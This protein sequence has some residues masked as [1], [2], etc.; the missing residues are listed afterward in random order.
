VLSITQWEHCKNRLRIYKH[1]KIR[2]CFKILM[3]NLNYKGFNKWSKS[4]Q[5]TQNTKIQVRNKKVKKKWY[6][7][8]QSPVEIKPHI[9][10]TALKTL[11][12]KTPP[13]IVKNMNHIWCKTY[14]MCII[15]QWKENT[16]KVG[17]CYRAKNM[18][19]NWGKQC[20]SQWVPYRVLDFDKMTMKSPCWETCEKY[21]WDGHA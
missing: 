4:H 21:S 11:M 6:K 10:L 17:C 15:N 20:S 16:N 5:C 13:T 3:K 8:V 12:L 19:V 2:Y 14:Y 18:K 7:V 9:S 1:K